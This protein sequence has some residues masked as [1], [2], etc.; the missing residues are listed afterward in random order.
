VAQLEMCVIN[1]DRVM[2]Q[3]TDSM[4]LGNQNYWSFGICPS[5]GI[6]DTRKHLKEG[7][8]LGPY[9]LYK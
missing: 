2:V 1:N 8:I 4:H 3:A 9:Q 6:P 5:S 7:Y